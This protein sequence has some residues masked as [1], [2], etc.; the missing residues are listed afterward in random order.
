MRRSWD[1]DPVRLGLAWVLVVAWAGLIF[2]LS[3]TPNLRFVQ[4][5]AIDFVVRKA[6][7]MAA[8]GILAV[9]LWR[10]V[11]YS[12]PRGAVAVSLALT[13]L[14][15]VSDEFHQSFTAGRH[16]SPVDV[17][18]DSAGAA[19]ALLALTVWLRLRS[20]RTG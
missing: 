15:A 18:I 2:A 9:L 14:Y 7:H 8:F 11:S 6:G 3:A 10:A 4:A 20:R 12:R 13:I 19:I 1:A 16:A 5:D 17:A